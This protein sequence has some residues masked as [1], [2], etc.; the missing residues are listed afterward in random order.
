MCC[1]HGSV[2]F[3]CKPELFLGDDGETQSPPKL[4]IRQKH[5]MLRYSMYST[6]TVQLKSTWGQDPDFS[7][8]VSSLLIQDTPKS[9]LLQSADSAL[10]AKASCFQSTL[11]WFSSLGW[12]W[13]FHR[14]STN[15]KNKCN[16]LLLLHSPLVH[17]NLYHFFSARLLKMC[18]VSE[19]KTKGARI[20]AASGRAR[21]NVCKN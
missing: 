8:G 2:V 15:L 6:C 18:S 21:A 17:K 16:I 20:C 9:T 13:P 10:V 3:F 1:A 4:N 5:E 12:R 7:S 19:A 14:D 11:Q